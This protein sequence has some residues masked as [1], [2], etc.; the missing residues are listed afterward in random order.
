MTKYQPM[1]D[2]LNNYDFTRVMSTYC[3]NCKIETKHELY[4]GH[5]F[6]E[7]M[8]ILLCLTCKR[9]RLE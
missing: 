9:R 2:D 6:A 1:L 7:G 5:T 4:D 8:C 3:D